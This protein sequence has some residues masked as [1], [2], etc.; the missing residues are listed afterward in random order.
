M[1]YLSINVIKNLFMKKIKN[2]NYLPRF[3]MFK[4]SKNKNT[5]NNVYFIITSYCIFKISLIKNLYTFEHFLII[6]VTLL[7]LILFE[8]FNAAITY[9]QS[10]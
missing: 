9:K 3:N 7:L 5:C 6:S 4:D 1:S 10:D 8:M 2:Y